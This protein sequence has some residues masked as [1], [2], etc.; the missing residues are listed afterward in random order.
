[1]VAHGFLAALLAGA[2]PAPLLTFDDALKRAEEH[3]LDLKVAQAKLAQAHELSRKLWA[4]YLPQLSVAG[5]YTRNSAEAKISLPTTYFVRDVFQNQGPAFDPSRPPGLDNPPGAQTPYILIPDPA[6]FVSLTI[7]PFNQWAGQASLSQAIIAPA[8]WPAIR[9]AYLGEN[10]AK[11]GTE[12]A[13]REILFAAAQLYYGAA[14]LK[15]ALKVQRRMLESNV[16]HE[17]DAQVRYQA[18]ALPKVAYL[19]AEIDRVRA[20]QD[21]K[22]S[23][24]GLESAKSALNAL[25]DQEGD[26]DVA[27]PAEPTLPADPSKLAES[28]TNDRPDLQAARKI[29]D[30]ALLQREG[31]WY[32]FLPNVGLTAKYSLSNITGFTGKYDSW[33]V[34]VGASWT[35]WDGGL[36]EAA[37]REN[38]QKVI[39]STAARRSAELKAADE[40]RRAL[41]ELDS[42]RANKVKASEQ[43]QLARENMGLVNVSYESGAATYLEV[44]DANAALLG[45][46]INAVAE[47]LNASLAGLKVLKAAGQFAAR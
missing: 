3:N 28:A 16:A 15:E 22:R 18:G 8:L 9:S 30:L 13:R 6:G 43:L 21:L 11:L 31:V 25:L 19:R 26:F 42:A 1:M 20:E 41:L 46:E 27:L 23:E 38:A 44:T 29:L 17:K 33:A 2:A 32:Q 36:R 5:G 35:I 12:T 24:N 34:G 7:Q 37:L 39:E 14:G 10:I 47:G 4:S 45:A 40:V